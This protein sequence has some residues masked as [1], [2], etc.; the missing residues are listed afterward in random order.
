MRHGVAQDIAWM[1]TPD[2]CRHERV[3]DIVIPALDLIDE[4]PSF[5]FEMQ[6]SGKTM[7]IQLGKSSLD[8]Y[9]LKFK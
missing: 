2:I 4:E 3:Y 9:K 7:N 5:K 1:N 8:T 6:Q